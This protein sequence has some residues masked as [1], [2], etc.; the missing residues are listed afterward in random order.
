MDVAAS[1]V[2]N[3]Q[4]SVL[5]DVSNCAFH[6]I[7][8]STQTA[9]VRRASMSE[10]R[11]DPHP[12]QDTF[13]VLSMVRTIGVESF[14]QTL[15]CGVLAQ[16]TGDYRRQ[17]PTHIM[18]VGCAHTRCQRHTSAVDHQVVLAP[19]FPAIRG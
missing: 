17:Q 18:D 6:H 14:G 4:S 5:V 10:H 1:F 12:P 15:H 2:T 9:A 7:P 19:I 11:F 8:H 16:R 3:L 13:T